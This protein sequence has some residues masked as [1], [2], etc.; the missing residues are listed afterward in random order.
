MMGM[1]MMGIPAPRPSVTVAKSPTRRPAMKMMMMM[2]HHSSKGKGMK[3]M[4]GRDLKG[5]GGYK[6]SL[7]SCGSSSNSAN[8]T[9]RKMRM[10]VDQ[11]TVT[12]ASIGHTMMKHKKRRH[13]AKSRVD[14][15]EPAH[16]T[17]TMH[18]KK[19]PRQDGFWWL[20]RW[21]PRK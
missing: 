3:G 11:T 16:K 21:V 18:R 4:K 7:E 15:P 19:P 20:G 5:K 8:R 1:M 13:P 12:T 17:I 6:G 10:R 9:M 14:S 2:C